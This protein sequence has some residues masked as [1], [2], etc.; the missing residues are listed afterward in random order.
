[1]ADILRDTDLI[2]VNRGGVNYKLTGAELKQ[3]D[4]LLDTDLIMVQESGQLYKVSVGTLRT[5]AGSLIDGPTN[6]FLAERED[7]L[8]SVENP[9]R[10]ITVPTMVCALDTSGLS[11]SS[12]TAFKVTVTG[13]AAIDGI[14][15]EVMGLRADNTPALIGK[16]L[17][18]SD[19]FALS[20]SDADTYQVA[21]VIV[22]GQFGSIRF[23]SS[24][25]LTNVK[26]AGG[27][28][29]WSRMFKVPAADNGMRMFEF[30]NKL[31]HVFGMTGYGSAPPAG[32]FQSMQ[33]TFKSCSIFNGDISSWDV[34]QV[35]SFAGTFDSAFLF[36]QPIDGWNVGNGLTF[37]RMFSGASAFNHA[38]NS[39]DVS[40]S[41]AF[42]S[43][44]FQ[45]T[46]F[47]KPLNNWTLTAL[48]ADPVTNSGLDQMFRLAAAFNEDLSGWCVSSFKG[49]PSLFAS[50]S[51][52]D[53]ANYPVWGTCP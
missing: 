44:F 30:C 11:S 7:Q 8:F 45:A 9:F 1:M 2:M 46:L 21:K 26:W 3:H 24:K 14:P 25:A 42:E 36:D 13:A 37:S 23:D 17:A 38:L 33:Q 19:S 31:T 22:Y 52:L 4:R 41:K 53:A 5:S 40:K 34:S 28:N 48:N 10:R 12:E 35:T 6:F 27:T 18:G 51:G 43:M 49:V 32:I 47:N 50:E 39:W 20:K 16:N 15:A 29:G